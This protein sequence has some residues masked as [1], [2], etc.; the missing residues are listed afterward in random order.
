MIR[1]SPEEDGMLEEQGYDYGEEL[2]RGD[3]ELIMESAGESRRR[4]L[5]ELIVEQVSHWI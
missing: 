5:E 4:L 2:E 3:V 1:S